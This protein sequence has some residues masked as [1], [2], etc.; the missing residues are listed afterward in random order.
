M[1]IITLSF[2]II[3]LC[4]DKSW[5]QK[6]SFKDWNDLVG[7]P[8][9]K[10]SR[11]DL[12]TYEHMMQIY[13]IADKGYASTYILDKG[14][15]ETAKAP[16]LAIFNEW[17]SD[18]KKFPTLPLPQ[19]ISQCLSLKSRLVSTSGIPRLFL[20]QRLNSCR[21]ITLQQLAP[22]ILSDKIILPEEFNFLKEFMKPLIHG[23][24]FA[25]FLWFMQ[26]LEKHEPSKQIVSQLITEYVTKTNSQVPRDLLP[27]MTITPE[28]TA[29]VQ[30]FGLDSESTKR[31]FQTEFSRWIEDSYTYIDKKPK[32]YVER[33]IRALGAWLKANALNLN[34]DASFSRYADLGKNLWRNG[35]PVL[36]QE[37]FDQVIREGNRDLRDDARFFRLWMWGSK[38]EWKEAVKWAESQKIPS[39]FDDID[40]SRLKFW[41]AFAYQSIDN[42]KEAKPL[43]ERVI[44]DHPLSFYAIMASKSLNA[45][46]PSS[47]YVNYY[48]EAVKTKTP[49]IKP[50]Q[51]SPEMIESIRRLRAWARLDYRE[52][53]S[54]ETRGLRR[55]VIPLNVSK[56]SA[57]EKSSVESDLYYLVC[58]MIGEEKNFLES[59]R[60]AYIALGTNK[61]EFGR[62][63]LE[64]LYPRPYFEHLLKTMKN[65]TADPLLVLS[66]IRQ[67]SV[68]NPQARSRVGAR[69]LMQLMPLTARRLKRGVREHQLSIPLT[70]LEIGTRYVE[71]LFKRYDGNLV[72]VLAAYNAGESRVTKWKEFYFVNDDML[73]NIESIPFL[74]TRNYV[75]LIFR[76][77]FF[78]KSLDAKKD[79][80][81]GKLHNK[82]HDVNLGFKR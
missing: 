51:I 29:H 79:I 71:Q 2:L 46:H 26:K 3:I 1:K 77:L 13:K 67:E 66:L 9:F 73:S 69:G 82:I 64:V 42:G 72:H 65:H 38:G 60:L 4:L 54:A 41:T 23:K 15:K 56:A 33:H 76:N 59:F 11:A 8:A 36:A 50:Q 5:A 74:E 53:L 34:R 44:A 70:N 47:P 19:L 28:L 39:H 20:T 37:I 12:I 52:F 48:Q 55:T 14:L 27:T 6:E 21:Q 25:D 43:F 7:F 45:H 30:N 35:F 10:I 68:F 22:K 18:L 78:Y 62:A 16:H 40:D 63:I 24:S 31:V 32:D 75:K 80:T 58:A 81:D 49:T 61:V 57:E 17:L